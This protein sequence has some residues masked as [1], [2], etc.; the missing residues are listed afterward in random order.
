M[1]RFGTT[2]SINCFHNQ[3]FAVVY[4]SEMEKIPCQL[5]FTFINMKNSEQSYNI[6][7]KDLLHS[8][9][10]GYNKSHL[11]CSVFLVFRNEKV[12]HFLITHFTENKVFHWC[13]YTYAGDC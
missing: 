13:V 11:I 8:L 2:F 5:A 4:W 3:E 9:A 1:Q 7:S 10:N 12:R 6:C